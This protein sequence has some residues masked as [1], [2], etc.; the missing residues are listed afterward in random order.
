MAHKD[1]KDDKKSSSKK[2]KQSPSATVTSSVS[3]AGAKGSKTNK[4]PLPVTRRCSCVSPYQDDRYGSGQ[5]LHNPCE[6]GM[7][8]RCSVCNHEQD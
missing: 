6:K 4:Y 1:Q 8:L 5:R 3:L 2:P 7:R